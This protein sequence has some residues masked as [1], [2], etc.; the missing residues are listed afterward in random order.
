MGAHQNAP[1]LRA[2]DTD[3]EAVADLLGAG[4]ASGRLDLAEFGD[5][6]DRAFAARTVGELV[7]LSADLPRP[8]V[9]APAARSRGV[10]L[11]L[12][13]AWVMWAL[14][15]TAVTAVSVAVALL[16]GLS[17]L[18]ALWFALPSG[19]ALWTATRRTRPHRGRR[20]VRR[21]ASRPTGR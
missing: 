19:L 14:L 3:R 7:E 5:R 8:A 18:W 4:L 20:L 17:L 2:A 16:A 12:W 15:A 10:T 11:L 9:E 1:G 6:L 21:G 13:L